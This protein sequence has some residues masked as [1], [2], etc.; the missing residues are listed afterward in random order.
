MKKKILFA[1]FA[2]MTASIL[3]AQTP[4]LEN[5]IEILKGDGF[6]ESMEWLNQL[7]KELKPHYSENDFLFAILHQRRAGIYESE[8]KYDKAIDERKKVISILE[9]NGGQDENIAYVW[10]DI[11]ME[12]SLAGKPYESIEAHKKAL[13]LFKKIFGD[14]NINVSAEY[15][16]IANEYAEVDKYDEAEKYYNKVIS[17]LGKVE[18][19]S[20]LDVSIFF[21][22]LGYYFN[23]K[24]DYA[25]AI[26]CHEKALE[27]LEKDAPDSPYMANCYNNLALCYSNIG[28][29]DKASAYSMKALKLAEN[30][31]GSESAEIR[32]FYNSRA[33]NIVE[34]AR[35]TSNVGEF[36]Q[37]VLY[38]N[39]SIALSVKLK[40]YDDTLRQTC[41]D[42]GSMLMEFGPKGWIERAA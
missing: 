36:N 16:N 40:T 27:I 12:Y 6:S 3:F 11:G 21:G 17:L 23:K 22:I 41:Q 34:N 29:D 1:F 35:R 19:M 32:G 38:Y 4:A 2:L 31:Y 8:Y 18:G 37:A 25:K 7:E 33:A 9:K 26:E 30:S 42:Y 24:N 5:K 10:Q 28:D 20:S 14:N 13:G 15:N 39:K